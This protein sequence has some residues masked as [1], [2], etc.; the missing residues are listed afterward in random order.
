MGTATET[1]GVAHQ[2]LDFS[3][4]LKALK[5]GKRIRRSTWGKNKK[6]IFEQVP[7]NVPSKF[8]EKM[9]SLPQSV[10]DYFQSTFEDEN[11]QISEIYYSDQIALVG[12]S[13]LITGYN[14]SN[15]DAFA[16]DWIIL[17]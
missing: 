9:T 10:K 12:N 2:E 4:A 5:E 14:L 15:S 11:A 17:H 16:K 1:V 7:S 3:K 6:F 8:V 13:N